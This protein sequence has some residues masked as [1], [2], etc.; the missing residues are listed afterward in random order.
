MTHW[1]QYTKHIK[2]SAD[3]SGLM[4]NQIAYM[5]DSNGQEPGTRSHVKIQVIEPDKSE[6]KGN[7][8][9]RYTNIL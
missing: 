2:L 6:W 9:A 5:T 4:M 1:E 3:V 7:H 8:P